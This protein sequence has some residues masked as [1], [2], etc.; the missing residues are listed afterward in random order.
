MPQAAGGVLRISCAT[1]L[2]GS[3]AGLAAVALSSVAAGH[4]GR[5]AG[6]AFKRADGDAGRAIRMLPGIALGAR[7]GPESIVDACLSPVLYRVSASEGARGQP[8][9][10]ERGRDALMAFMHGWQL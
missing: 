6:A 3:A 7:L 2:L 8:P 10:A 1:P 9:P 4:M 5:S